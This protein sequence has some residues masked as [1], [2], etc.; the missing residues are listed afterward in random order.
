MVRRW[1][2]MRGEKTQGLEDKTISEQ[3]FI[4]VWCRIYEM[5]FQLSLHVTLERM[6]TCSATVA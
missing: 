1:K 5:T 4:F 3:Q 6:L 2:N